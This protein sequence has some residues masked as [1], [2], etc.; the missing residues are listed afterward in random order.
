MLDIYAEIRELARIDTIH[1]FDIHRRGSGVAGVMVSAKQCEQG[2][3]AYACVEKG[4]HAFALFCDDLACSCKDSHREHIHNQDSWRTIDEI[5]RAIEDPPAIEK[6]DIF[7]EWRAM[8]R[9]IQSLAKQVE[10]LQSDHEQAKKDFLSKHMKY[11][12]MIPLIKAADFS[13]SQ[14][15]TA[16]RL[17]SCIE[18]HQTVPIFPPA[19]LHKKEALLGKVKSELEEEMERVCDKVKQLW[20]YSNE[21][22]LV[23]R[24]ISEAYGRI[25]QWT[26]NLK[27][28]EVEDQW[29]ESGIRV[30]EIVV[31][32]GDKKQEEV[33]PQIC[34]LLVNYSLTPTRFLFI[35]EHLRQLKLL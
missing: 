15:F 16:E 26:K 1:D 30:P 6:A 10:K 20:A 11:A 19:Y 7:Q 28:S 9:I 2:H 24:D 3:C 22:T 33:P 25:T 12:E 8:E 18:E 21:E 29:P 13:V 5:Q 35:T 17:R 31:G 34:S 23:V 14:K 4:C 32:Y 27:V